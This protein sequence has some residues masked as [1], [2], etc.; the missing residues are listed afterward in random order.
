[1]S[2]IKSIGVILFHI[3]KMQYKKYVNKIISKL[4]YLTGCDYLSILTSM[5]ENIIKE[6][7]TASASNPLVAGD[8]GLKTRA[9]QHGRESA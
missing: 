1:M 8:P 9:Q 4:Q 3:Y 5:A 7:A 6:M 2:I